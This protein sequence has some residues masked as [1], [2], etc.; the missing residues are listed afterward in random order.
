MKAIEKGVPSKVNSGSATHPKITVSTSLRTVGG[1]TDWVK[2]EET[3]GAA[4]SVAAKRKTTDVA[5]E[6]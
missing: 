2:E 1:S 3:R 4:K 6:R 5:G